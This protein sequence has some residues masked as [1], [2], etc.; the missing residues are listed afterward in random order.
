MDIQ[1]TDDFDDEEDDGEDDYSMTEFYTRFPYHRPHR[2]P[3]EEEYDEMIWSIETHHLV[4]SG[5]LGTNIRI[6]DI[7]HV[8]DWKFATDV[9]YDLVPIV[10]NEVHIY[11]NHM[12]KFA[13]KHGVGGPFSD[14]FTTYS[15]WGLDEMPD[16]RPPIPVDRRLPWSTFDWRARPSFDSLYEVLA[17]TFWEKVLGNVDPS[18][19]SMFPFHAFPCASRFPE[20][21]D[22]WWK[23][24]L[25]L[26]MESLDNFERSIG[27][28][29]VSPVEFGREGN[30]VMTQTVMPSYFA[31]KK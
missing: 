27:M 28:P 13:T 3:S 18:L 8:T 24:I 16:F 7:F 26:F 31:P 29:P 2:W 14:I 30:T 15:N 10:R 6:D 4:Y 23:I 12:T 20:V 5:A 1:A 21:V 22:Q 25:H 11:S 9:S 17:T 19:A